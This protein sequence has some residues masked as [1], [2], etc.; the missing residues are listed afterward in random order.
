VKPSVTESHHL[1]E[2]FFIS[3]L[4]LIWWKINNPRKRLAVPYLN[5]NSNE[6]VKEAGS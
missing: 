5:H 3:E 6:A 1:R 2:I 4:P